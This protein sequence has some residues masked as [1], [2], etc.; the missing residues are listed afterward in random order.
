M[1]YI[2]VKGSVCVEGI[3]LTV[4]DVA[5]SGFQVSLIA[6]TKKN[7]TLGLKRVGEAVNIEV[8]MLARY[9]ERLIRDQGMVARDQGI[10][11]EFLGK[12]GFL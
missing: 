5:S 12:Y 8:D 2:A 7:T 11:R 1:K 4:M 6:F 9:V 10:D 3:S